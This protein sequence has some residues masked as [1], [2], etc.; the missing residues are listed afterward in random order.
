[1]PDK[2]ISDFDRAQSISPDDILLG[3][4]NGTPPVTKG[5]SWGVMLNFLQTNFFNAKIDKPATPQNQQFLQ[6]NG[7]AWVAANIPSTDLS[8]LSAVLLAAVQEAEPIKAWV[9]FDG[10]KDSDGNTSTLNTDRQIRASSNVSS[11]LRNTAGDYT[12][13]FT[14]PLSDSNYIL[15][16]TTMSQGGNNSGNLQIRRS[17][18]IP[19]L[20]NQTQA[21]VI[22]K[23]GSENSTSYDDTE[24][25]CAF[26]R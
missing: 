16:P 10:T 20:K 1:M 9:N 3:D 24:L 4:Q 11:V 8:G 23:G 26:V 5:F 12:I 22:L 2:H 18:S 7:N 17:G 14:T 6:Y 25:Y 19:T 21:R 13:T 15:L